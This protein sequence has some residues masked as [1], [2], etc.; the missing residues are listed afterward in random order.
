MMVQQ[1]FHFFAAVLWMGIAASAVAQS[2]GS[3]YTWDGT[4]NLR[5]WVG[6]TGSP[7]LANANVGELTITETAG[8]TTFTV[9]DDFNVIREPANGSGGL[10]LTGLDFLEFDL[11]HNGAG[12]VN[13]QFFVQAS[14]S[15]TFIAL[16]PDVAVGP[17]IST[18]QVPISQLTYPQGVYVRTVGFIARDHVELGPLTWTLQEVRSAGTPLTERVLITHDTGTPEGGLQG[19][20]ANFDREAVIGNDGGQNQTGLSHNA[21]GSG[22][23]QWTDQGHHG[24]DDTSGAA[25]TWGNG[26]AWNGNSFNL[27]QTDLSNY[28]HMIVTMSATDQ[29]GNGGDLDMRAFFQR[30]SGFTF[31][32]VAQYASLPID[33]QFHEV[34]FD[35][36]NQTLMQNVNWTGLDLF[37]HEHDLVIN[38]D[39]I[40]FIQVP[41]PASVALI[42]LGMI[43]WLGMARRGRRREGQVAR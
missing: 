16:A 26:T 4:G 9:R 2:P 27:R 15:S 20:I 31:E 12:S 37:P 5:S 14:P 36:T 23:L 3:I 19:A 29:G 17:G 21:S 24:M 43:G 30:G 1:R 33:G 10:D 38:V 41:E 6:T 35:L 11:G 8:G 28:S 32:E 34:T 40:R 39:Q 42:G 7:S 18:Y 25:I 13:V 22:S